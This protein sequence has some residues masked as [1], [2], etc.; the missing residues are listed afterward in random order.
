MY[1][2]AA[3]HANTGSQAIAPAASQYVSNYEQRIR[4]GR[5]RYG[6]GDKKESNKLW[7]QQ[8]RET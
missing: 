7:I 3:A 4:A 1:C 6:A 8:I 5:Q 2:Q